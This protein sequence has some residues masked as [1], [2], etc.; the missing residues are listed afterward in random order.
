MKKIFKFL[1]WLDLLFG[2]NE[3]F[4]EI[5]WRLKCQ[6]YLVPMNKFTYDLIN[7]LI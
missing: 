3:E 4:E 1:E 5:S 7:D 2:Y 6:E